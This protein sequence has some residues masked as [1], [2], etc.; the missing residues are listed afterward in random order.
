MNNCIY[1]SRFHYSPCRECINPK[2][3][4]NYQDKL[5]YERP[6]KIKLSVRID[7]KS[8]LIK[9]INHRNYEGVI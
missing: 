2:D 6:I 3:C 8:M 4:L 1:K 7:D 9:R 5:I